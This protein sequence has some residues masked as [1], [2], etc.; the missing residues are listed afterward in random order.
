MA[1]DTARAITT[2]R[3]LTRSF[4]D[5]VRAAT[6]FWPAIATLNTSTGS[7][8]KYGLLGAMPAVREW[9]GDRVFNTLRGGSYTI[10]NRSWENSLQ[11]EREDIEDDRLGMYGPVLQ[12]MGNEASYHP[13]ELMFEQIVLGLTTACW[14]G[15]FFFDTD[16]AWGDSGT[17]SNDLTYNA[18]DHT[19]VTAAEFLAAYHVNLQTMTK[20]KRDNG[21]FYNRPTIKG[22]GSMMVVVPPELRE[23]ATTA[24]ESALLGGGNTNVVL[25]KPQVVVSPHLTDASAFYTFHTGQA[26]KPF[27]FQARRPLARQMKG[28]DDREFKAVKFM[29]DARYAVGFLAWWNAVYC[30]FN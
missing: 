17:Q 12:Q 10:E 23:A 5:G 1:L 8:E 7:D 4:D 14:D 6:P 24:F 16:H 29:T 11:I 27:V 18:S 20:F 3:D 2:V 15:Q 26:L 21:K 9:L 28:L 13:D 30:D 22:M 25:D 19:A